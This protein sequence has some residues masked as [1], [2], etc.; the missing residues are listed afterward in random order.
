M[1]RY[2]FEVIVE[3]GND[4]FW[5]RLINEGS[6]GCDEMLISLTDAIN[7]S[8]QMMGMDVKINLVKYENR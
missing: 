5:E 8:A 3:E 1:K 6:T 2:L 7:D 4:E